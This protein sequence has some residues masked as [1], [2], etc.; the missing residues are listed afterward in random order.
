[1][2]K[3]LAIARESAVQLL[4][5]ALKALALL[6]ILEEEVS[7]AATL[8]QLDDIV[9]HAHA[10]QVGFKHLKAVADR[11]GEVRVTGERTLGKRLK[12]LPKAKGGA[13]VGVGRAGKDNA[14][15]THDRIQAPTLSDIGISKDRS[16][17]AQKLAGIPKSKIA[18]AVKQLS[19]D[20]KPISAAAILR[21]ASPKPTPPK[22]PPISDAGTPDTDDFPGAEDDVEPENFRTAFLMRAATA[23][24]MC[25]YSGPVD[26]ETI[27]A[28]RAVA[29][30]WSELA[31]QMES[32]K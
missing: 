5:S 25:A 22:R 26:M 10:I 6:D 8:E 12:E 13:E 2:S 16:S 4:P 30:A 14:V 19:D 23:K 29:S 21:I 15:V 27:G 24:Q 32:R 7:A 20:D 28:A 11:A 17:R 18:A 9:A 3:A 31:H 1:M